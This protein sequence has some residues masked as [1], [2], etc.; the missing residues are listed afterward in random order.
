MDEHRRQHLNV[1]LDGILTEIADDAAFAAFK[2]IEHVPDVHIDKHP[3]LEKV[4]T[5]IR[6][7]MRVQI[8]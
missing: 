2:E 1:K 4:G 5:A 8:P 3:F 7:L 6:E